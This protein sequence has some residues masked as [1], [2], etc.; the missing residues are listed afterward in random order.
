MEASICPV[1]FDDE[2]FDGHEQVLFCSDHASGL[3]AIIAI[4]N[5]VRGPALGGTRMWAYCSPESALR[6]ALRLSRAM[7]YKSALAGVP[8]GGGKAVILGDPVTTKTEA[9]LCAY[10]RYV[11]R[12]GGQFVTGEDVGLT[13]GDVDVIATATQHTRGTSNG[14]TGD[15]STYTALGVLKGIEAA[16]A[17]RLGGPDLNGVAVCVQ[18]LGNVGMRLCQLLDRAGASLTVSDI[19][20]ERARDAA[21][22]FNAKIVEPERAYAANVDVFAPCAL[23]GELNQRTIPAIRA[24]VVA[25]SANAQLEAGE[26]GARLRL[27]NILYAPDYVINAGGLLSVAHDVPGFDPSSLRRDV[28]R[29]A[30]TLRGIFERAEAEDRSTSDVADSIAEEQ[31]DT[32]RHDAAA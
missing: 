2:E 6:D 27:R 20:L 22:Q 17:Y 25:G 14:H 11:E 19:R 12:L 1:V 30:D 31:L 10:A 3:Q 16:V 8:Y 4:H 26:D 5:T 24:G 32:L 9:L 21:S 15:P 13:V 23:S 7:S 29:I 18:G 28:S